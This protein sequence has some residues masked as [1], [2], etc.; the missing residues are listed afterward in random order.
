MAP[1]E[2]RTE[3]P[4]TFW[5]PAGRSPSSAYAT[6][7][8]SAR[9]QVSDRSALHDASLPSAAKQLIDATM[10]KISAGER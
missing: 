9:S 8:L 6:P 10:K 1:V 7:Q 4:Q 5:S 3:Q 2:V